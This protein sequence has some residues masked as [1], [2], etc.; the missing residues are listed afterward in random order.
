MNTDLG[1]LNQG[2]LTEWEGSVQLTTCIGQL[3]FKLAIDFSFCT[4]KAILM[5]RPTI[6]SLLLQSSSM[7]ECCH[8]TFLLYSV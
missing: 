6:L 7:F 5:M 4:K 3:F 1:E 2:I 8:A